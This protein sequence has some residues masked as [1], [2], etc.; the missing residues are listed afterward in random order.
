MIALR[1]NVQLLAFLHSSRDAAG[2]GAGQILP[3]TYQKFGLFR[4]SKLG[5]SSWTVYRQV[6]N[7]SVTQL[8][9]IHTLIPSFSPPRTVHQE[10]GGW[11][12][13]GCALS[14]LLTQTW[15]HQVRR[16]P[17]FRFSD[18]PHPLASLTR[19]QC[20]FLPPAATCHTVVFQNPSS[21]ARIISTHEDPLI[22]P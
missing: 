18:N 14:G 5:Q 21:R 15:E 16:T 22:H 2:L 11:Q 8:T 6:C 20:S 10:G 3:S 7:S 12:R 19:R 4:T 17:T 13:C 1:T 9:S